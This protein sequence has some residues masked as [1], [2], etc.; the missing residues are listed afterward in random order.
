MAELVKPVERT[1]PLVR[2]GRW[3]VINARWS[4][5]GARA[6]VDV[7]AWSAVRRFVLLL[8]IVYLA[9]QVIYALL[10]PAFTGHDEV[11]HYAHLR[12]VATEGR[13]PVVP[14]LDEWRG[15]Y[16]AGE[17]VPHDS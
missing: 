3:S 17:G 5:S 16:T 1:E 4:L 11:A 7:R 2:A 6:A 12:I 8:A 10:F 13:Y 15:Q 14:D 9:K